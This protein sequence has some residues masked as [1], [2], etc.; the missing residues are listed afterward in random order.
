MLFF[1]MPVPELH[2]HHAEQK[3]PGLEVR[4]THLTV[5]LLK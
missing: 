5:I 3:G 1:F 4:R 2:A